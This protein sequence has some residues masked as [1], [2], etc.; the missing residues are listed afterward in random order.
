MAELV[1]RVH[2]V[3]PGTQM[4]DI[5]FEGQP[6]QAAIPN[7]VVELSWDVKDGRDHGSLTMKFVGADIPWAKETFVQDGEVAV[8]FAKVEAETKAA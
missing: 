5:T 1:Y 7:M 3:V 4:Q 8:S 6:V 2:S